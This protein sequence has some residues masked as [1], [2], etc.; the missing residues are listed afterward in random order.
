MRQLIMHTDCEMLN[1]ALRYSGLGMSIIP[2]Y[3]VSK[4]ARIP[5]LPYQSERADEN[6][7]REWF[8]SNQ[9]NVGVVLGSVS[10]GL[11]C[12]DFDSH[13]SYTEWAKKFADLASQLPTV[14][15]ARGFHVYF[16][17]VLSSSKS[18]EELHIDM[19]ASGYMLLPPSVHES[20]AIYTW[21]NPLR[22][23]D[24]LPVLDPFQWFPLDF[25]QDNQER[26]ENQ[27]SQDMQ[28]NQAI[29]VYETVNDK[30]EFAIAKT[31]PNDEGQRNRCIFEFCRKLKAIPELKGAENNILRPIVQQ[32]HTAALPLISTKDFT[33]TWSDFVYGWGKV[34]YPEGETLLKANILATEQ[35]EVPQ[36]QLDYDCEKTRFLIRLC[37]QLQQ[38]RCDKS[39]FF[40]GCRD[41][42][43]CSGFSHTE[44]AKRLK[45][46]VADGVLKIVKEHS[47]I[48]AT[49]YCFIKETSNG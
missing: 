41:A 40:I 30:I 39:M 18:L 33:T 45:M 14:E 6:K 44:A 12:C 21:V 16:R 46:L 15:T 37:Y 10:G 47:Q 48:H 11:T 42:G 2:V 38:L 22:S 3:Q 24:E 23:V 19:K 31:I 35:Q 17:S 43:K 28:E 13:D 8:F 1:E 36:V 4:I 29:G 25:T 9:S 5:W 49:D 34:R 27:D 32:W 26:Q 20:G 7:L